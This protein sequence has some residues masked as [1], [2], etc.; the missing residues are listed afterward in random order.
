MKVEAKKVVSL[1]YELKNSKD[2]TEI[3]EKLT[4]ES[5]LQFIFGNGSML[6]E[7]ENNIKDLSP[8]DTFNFM[9]T[10]EQGYGEIDEN[11]IIELSKDIFMADGK[12]REDLVFVGN[13]IPMKDANGNLINGKVLKINEN[14]IS[15]DFNHAMA[16]SSLFFKG[17]IISI[18]AATA[19][20]LQ[21]GH[22]HHENHDCGGCS[23]CG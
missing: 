3:T 15:M 4:K 18:R 12:L 5:P 2:A 13:S 20:E 10:A 8:G 16:G 9:L 7:F 14:T 6:P 17:E 19:E 23:S 22:I 1:S 21:H 11:A